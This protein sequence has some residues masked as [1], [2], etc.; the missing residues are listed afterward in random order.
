MSADDKLKREIA[1]QES[2]E[3]AIRATDKAKADL[4]RQMANLRSEGEELYKLKEKEIEQYELRIKELAQIYELEEQE[5]EVMKAKL[6]TLSTTDA[7]YATLT[8]QI[9][10]ATAELAVLNTTT[11]KEVTSLEGLTEAA[12]ESAEA[13]KELSEAGKSLANVL[14]GINNNLLNTLEAADK[15]EGGIKNLTQGFI[16]AAFAGGKWKKTLGAGFL[17]ISELATAG[18]MALGKSMLQL[19]FAQDEA[20]SG[21]MKATGAAYEFAAE[22][23]SINAALHSSGISAQ[24]AGKAYGGLYN[25]F[26]DFTEIGPSMRGELGRNVALLQELGVSADTS[27]K[28]LDT[29]MR[30]LGL[31]AKEANKLLL[32]VASIAQATRQPFT[33]VAQDFA[34]VA[35]KLTKYG[36]N[37][38]AVFEGLEKQAK[39]TGIQMGKLISVTEQFDTFEGAGRAVGRLNAILGGPY[40]N[41]IDMLNATDEERIDI[42]Q[43]LTEQSGIQFDELNRY[44]QMNIAKAMGTDVD[45]AR[46]MMGASTAEFEKQ[47]LAQ[48]RLAAMA[49]ESQTLIDQLKFAF[50]SAL[51]GMRPI[52][53]EFIVPFIHGLGE[54]NAGAPKF[55][56]NLDKIA[57]WTLGI[58]GALGALLIFIGAMVSASGA[59][60]VA[61]V[62]MIMA[63]AKL[64]GIGIGGGLLK[65]QIKSVGAKS[66]GEVLSAG[67]ERQKQFVSD[68]EA[69]NIP[70]FPKFATGGT[71][72]K[73]RSGLSGAIIGR[74]LGRVLTRT[75]PP[76]SALT[77]V[78]EN[79]PELRESPVGSRVTNAPTTAKLTAGMQDLTN[80][81]FRLIGKMDAGGEGQTIVAQLQI[82]EEVFTE[83]VIKAGKSSA[84]QRAV[85]GDMLS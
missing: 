58:S 23:P 47:Q 17:K 28:I 78:G 57:S 84:F 52:I 71:V 81:L 48:E 63:G 24:D 8:A 72:L 42:L 33:K 2:L 73:P 31:H 16:K 74:M 27:G 76:M 22:I 61:G 59:G 26:V 1:Q 66:G 41:A 50:Q 21:F 34:T 37:M 5:L 3:R 67:R 62:P 77:I 82:G 30:S 53:E 10:T 65:G 85:G 6:A 68:V 45:T 32:E 25:S 20:V 51:V 11:D 35:P 18:V 43:R 79:G 46:R 75:S 55:L 80:V 64:L 15:A 7:A 83:Q 49:R 60:A 36:N 54:M 19:A 70:D 40:L 12:K 9:A 44:E 29:A 39:R 13:Q 38:M 69:V 4:A 56:A 14:F